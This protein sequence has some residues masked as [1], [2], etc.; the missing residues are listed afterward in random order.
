MPFRALLVRKYANIAVG[1]ADV[2]RIAASPASIALYV[3]YLFV[4]LVNSILIFLNSIV[5]MNRNPVVGNV[6]ITR[7][8]SNVLNFA[9]GHVA[10]NPV[11]NVSRAAIYALG[12]VGKSALLF[13]VFATRT[14]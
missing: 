1:T 14:S 4:V 6:N 10:M 3:F 12:S 7:V 2:A 13:A 11:G 8:H 9:S 5:L